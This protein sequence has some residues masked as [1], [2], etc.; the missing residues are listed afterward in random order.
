MISQDQINL[1]KEK[2]IIGKRRGR[3]LYKSE[4]I[5]DIFSNDGEWLLS[6]S[7]KVLGIEFVRYFKI[8]P[9]GKYLYLD[10]AEPYPH[11]KKFKIE[12]VKL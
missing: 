3:N 4:S 7:G 6:F 9:G 2:W 11:I 12:F 5:F 10:Y 8:G 1:I